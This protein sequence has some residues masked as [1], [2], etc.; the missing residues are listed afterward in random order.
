MSD[1]DDPFARRDTR[2][3]PSRQERRESVRVNMD[4]LVKPFGSDQSPVLK[5]GQLSL[6][7]FF[8]EMDDALRHA[9][10]EV[11]F[12]LP[13]VEEEAITI[14]A[15]AHPTPNNSG[16]IVR[17]DGISFEEERIIARFLDEHPGR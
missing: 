9:T 15:A 3:F 5:K 17:F 2:P 8:F 1:F 10:V 6:A 16:L 11:T 4:G 14:T 12:E 7:G 13:G